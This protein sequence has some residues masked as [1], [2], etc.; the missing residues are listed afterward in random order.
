M[1][2][3]CGYRDT[4]TGR[5][6]EHLVEAAGRCAAGHPVARPG[7]VQAEAGGPTYIAVPE[8][9]VGDAAHA[10]AATAGENAMPITVRDL[11]EELEVWPE[12][13]EIYRDQLVDIDGHDAV[14][15]DVDRDLLSD[16]A[17]EDIRRSVAEAE[18]APYMHYDRGGVHASPALIVDEPPPGTQLVDEDVPDDTSTVIRW[19]IYENGFGAYY[20]VRQE[21]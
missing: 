5:P 1:S 14:I 17:A 8:V 21:G 4:T 15:V 16:Q 9:A 13:I 10:G 12:I 3:R 11:A 18:P 20:A 7:A 19:Q 6:C 2:R